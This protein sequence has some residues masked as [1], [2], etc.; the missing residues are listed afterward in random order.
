MRFRLA[1]YIRLFLLFSLVTGVIPA[2]GQKTARAAS[3]PA[4]AA[5]SW[6]FEDVLR[7]GQQGFTQ[8]LFARAGMHGEVV[9]EG[10]RNG[11]EGIYRI[12]EGVVSEVFIYG[13][14]L[15]GLGT[16]NDAGISPYEYM[17]LP[18]ADILFKSFLTNSGQFPDN[19]YFFR[20]RNGVISMLPPF[21]E[22]QP[23]RP[24]THELGQITTDNRWVSYY[25][26]GDSFPKTLFYT[27]GDGA[28]TQPLANIEASLATF[29]TCVREYG[30]VAGAD[31]NGA[32][33]EYHE[34]VTEANNGAVCFPSMGT[35]K[36][37]ELRLGGAGGA[38]LTSGTFL[39]GDQPASGTLL[40]DS[41]PIIFNHQN[42]V[43]AIRYVYDVPGAFIPRR[44]L[45]IFSPDGE[46][47]IQD[48]NGP[49]DRMSLIDF[50][51]HGR[52]LYQ[53]TPDNNFLADILL[54]GPD[55]TA[56]KVIARGDALFGQTVTSLGLNYRPSALTDS[57]DRI[58]AFR[59]S[60]ADGSVGIALAAQKEVRLPVIILPG[61]AGSYAANQ[62]DDFTWLMNR[63]VHPDGLVVDPLGGFYDDI[64]LTF[65]AL[66][67]IQGEDLFVAN[68]DWRLPPGPLDGSIDGHVDGLSGAGIS[69]E[70][71]LYGVDYLGYYLR[72]AAEAWQLTHG[73]P[74]EKVHVIAHSTGGLVAR[75]YIQSDAYGDLYEAGRHLPTIEHFIM[76]GV[77]NR[78]ASK[79]YNPL[80]DNWVADP[81]YQMLL[82]KIVNRAYEKVLAGQTI[83]GPDYDIQLL[84]IQDGAGVPDPV[85]FIELYVPTLR[86]LLA[87]YDFYSDGGAYHDLNETDE[88]NTWILDLNNGLDL[89]DVP[90]G[91][92]NAFANLCTLTVI[93]GTSE[94]TKWLTRKLTGPAEDVLSPFSDF[95]SNNAAAGQAYHLDIAGNQNGEGSV[96]TLSAAG[97]FIGDPRVTLLPM[98]TG[99]TTTFPAD[100]TALVGNLTVQQAILDRLGVAHSLGDIHLG[101]GKNLSSVL[102]VISDPVEFVLQD[103][104]GRRL[105]YTSATGKLEEIPGSKW[106]GTSEGTGWLLGEVVP[107]LQ[108]TLTGLGEAY[109]VHVAAS[110]PAF[111]GGWSAEGTML[112]AG[113]TMTQVVPL[114][115]NG[116][117]VFLPMI[118]Q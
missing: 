57:L 102:A 15:P 16:L 76:I 52:I 91:D 90:P 109:Y 89:G 25:S 99:V 82:S 59:Y 60:L 2:E 18:N 33:V 80:Q 111:R 96:P 116:V 63:G 70:S 68:Y 37:W 73:E 69:D 115:S 29:P 72:Q 107:P 6:Q 100:H 17:V 58:F 67:Y 3:L 118:R 28:N 86:A 42:Q 30:F 51:H 38:V 46:E 4:A 95:F 103:G 22:T 14:T 36:N 77:P 61:I 84:D 62:V 88:L 66:G 65:E 49:V 40:P 79:P 32:S 21:S 34:T 13:M 45:V 12:A 114:R 20:W 9:F 78:G 26:S 71:F 93:Y 27:L 112:A 85:K 92:P 43:A 48:T 117:R 23:P 94:N 56:N 5:V 1:W 44:Q 55:L 81:A 19:V 35:I 108:V 10:I 64:V 50:D 113:E 53:V 97:Q 101:A 31:A 98:T 8:I 83:N 75:T 105:G 41:Q 106:F 74:L 110:T 54:D 104:L 7:V 47:I 87:T 24:V 11:A 39:E